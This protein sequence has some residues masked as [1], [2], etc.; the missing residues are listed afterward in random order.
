MRE[1]R[2]EAVQ[3]AVETQAVHDLRPVGLEPAVHVV[4]THAGERA[5]NA[6]EEAGK[7]PPRDRIAAMRLPAGDKI[8]ALVQ[9]GEQSRDLSGIVLQ[10]AVDGDHGLSLSLVEAGHE[11]GGLAEVAPES[12]DADVLL[13]VVQP[14]E[15][16]E[17][18]VGGAVVDEDRLP[19]GAERLERRPELVV[20]QCDASLFV[21]H[22]YDDGDHGREVIRW[23]QNG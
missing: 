19:R 1:H 16:G 22:R 2:D 9:L 23:A 12:N 4:Q 11:C 17:C 20:E 10:V 8:E 5:R 15:R 13:G 18:S 14:S 6:V 21:M 7:K 3:L